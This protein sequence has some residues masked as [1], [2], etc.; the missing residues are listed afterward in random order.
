MADFEIEGTFEEQWGIIKSAVRAHDK[1]LYGNGQPGIVDFIAQ[2]R[3]QF[4]LIIALLSLIL[5]ALGVYAALEANRQ[6]HAKLLPWQQN[7]FGGS[8]LAHKNNSQ[9]ATIPSQAENLMR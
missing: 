4:K 7:A 2:T 8:M 9:N 5:A 1:T 3:G 6:S